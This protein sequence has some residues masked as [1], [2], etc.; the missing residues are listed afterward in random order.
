[1]TD[2]L[3]PLATCFKMSKLLASEWGEGCGNDGSLQKYM[4]AGPSANPIFLALSTQ[5]VCVASPHDPLA[6]L[7]CNR[8]NVARVS[9]LS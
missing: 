8:M 5:Y 4:P 1:M 3:F 9:T 7:L 2:S 6:L